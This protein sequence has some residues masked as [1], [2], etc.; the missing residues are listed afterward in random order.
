MGTP[1]KAAIGDLVPLMYRARWV[2][3]GMSGEVR[4]RADDTGSVGW[5]EREVF[6]VAP[7]GRYRFEVIDGEGD[8]EVRTGDMQAAR[9]RFRS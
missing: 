7:D 5:E 6:E 9:C 8:R 2:R 4:S 3:F 1:P